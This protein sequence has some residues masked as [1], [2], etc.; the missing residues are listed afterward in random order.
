[1]HMEYEQCLYR[2]LGAAKDMCQRAHI[3]EHKTI[4]LKIRVYIMD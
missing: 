1:M 3:P 2:W 4:V